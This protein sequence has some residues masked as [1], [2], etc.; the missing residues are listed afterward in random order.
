MDIGKLI[1]KKAKPEIFVSFVLGKNWIQAG[2]WQA[3]VERGQLLSAGTISPWQQDTASFIE[4]ADDSLA[5][6]VGTL[7]E[8]PQLSKVVFGLPSFW[9]DQGKVQQEKLNLLKELCE[10]LELT[11]TGFVIIPEAIVYMMRQKEGGGGSFILLGLGEEEIEIDLVRA[12]HV[13]ETKQVARSISLGDDAIE[14][15]NRFETQEV[16]PARIILYNRHAAELSQARQELIAW[17]WPTSLFLHTPRIEIL[18]PDTLITAVSESAAMEVARVTQFQIAYKEEE[19]SEQKVAEEIKI[20][21]EE[22]VLKEEPTQDSQKDLYPT[23]PEVAKLEPIT[24]EAVAQPPQKEAPKFLPTSQI[25]G[26]VKQSAGFLGGIKQKSLLIPLAVLILIAAA[27]SLWYL[28]KATVTAYLAP[29]RLEEGVLLNKISGRNISAS[30]NGEKTSSPTGT[31]VVGDR[32]K[33]EVTIFN[34][35]AADRAFTQGTV[36]TGSNGLKFTLDREVKVASESGAPNYKPGEKK[37]QVTAG[38]IGAEYNLAAGNIFSIA[39]FAT[40]SFSGKNDSPLFG[41]SSREVLAVKEDDQ[42][43]LEQDLIAELK[44]KALTNLSPHV[45]KEEILIPESA[46]TKAIS[47]KFSAKPGEEANT[48]SLVLE[49]DVSFFVVPKDKLFE[50]IKS[51]LSPKIPPEFVLDEEQVTVRFAKEKEGFSARVT[52]LLLPKLDNKELARQ[53][54]GKTPSGTR[55]VLVSLPGFTRSTIKLSPNIP[56]L[57]GM[58][59]RLPRRAENITIEMRAEQ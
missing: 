31:K 18:P 24:E 52:A 42:K 10:K 50:E 22:K 41:G 21:E 6:A 53:L 46:D 29:K 44:E 39:N 19:I 9:V 32:A 26:W 55:S 51:A 4:A 33:G 2:I 7:P 14:G 25:L 36:L 27:F 56:F 37:V 57:P 48:L 43:L 1:G 47:R 17:E 38:D 13:V 15:L 5:S 12:G 28:P 35:T 3:E 11:P 34:N 20:E 59:G 49:L 40:S 16:L 30:V 8:P 23:V 54:A 58:L 45:P